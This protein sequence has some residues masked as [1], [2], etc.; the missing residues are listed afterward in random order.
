MVLI[1]QLP[2]KIVGHA[3]AD[4]KAFAL[5][6]GYFVQEVQGEYMSKIVS[7]NA[8]VIVGVIGILDRVSLHAVKARRTDVYRFRP[9][10]GNLVSQ[11]RTEPPLELELER[12]ISWRDPHCARSSSV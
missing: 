7:R 5:A 1:C 9:G 6:Y 11:P 3:V 8:P 12:I 2:E 4:P 10:I